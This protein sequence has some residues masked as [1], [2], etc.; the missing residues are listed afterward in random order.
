MFH[1]RFVGLTGDAAALDAAA[2]AYRVFYARVALKSPTTRG[3][4]RLHLSDGTARRISA[5]PPGTPADILVGTLPRL[6]PAVSGH[7]YRW[8]L[9]SLLL[10]T[11]SFGSFIGLI[12]GVG[13]HEGAK[14]WKT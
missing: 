10:A 6:S 13:G 7:R 4:L 11:E 9:R 14:S 1:A 5:F 12:Q 3:P 8:P 2:R